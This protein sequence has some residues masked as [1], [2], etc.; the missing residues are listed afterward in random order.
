V[1]DTFLYVP[2]PWPLRL[3]APVG[4]VR[5]HPTLPKA[6]QRR[7]GAAQDFRRWAEELAERSRDVEHLC[8]AHT[9]MLSNPKALGTSIP[10]LLREALVKAEP[11][12]RA[13]ER[14]FG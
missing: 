6:L 14:K 7:A 13:H 8:A 11:I 1:D 10:V 12:L 2:L 3:L 5:I 9:A 4:L